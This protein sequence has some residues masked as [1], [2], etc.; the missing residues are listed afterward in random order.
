MKIK[1][2]F[3]F[4]LS[5]LLTLPLGYFL[6]DRIEFVRTAQRINAT[7]EDI[8]ASNDRCGRKRARYACTKYQARLRY[9]VQGGQYRLSVSAGQSRG[10][11]QPISRAEYRIGGTDVVAY[12]PRKPSRGYRDRTWDIWG[13]PVVTFFIQIAAF[14]GS[15]SEQR[16]RY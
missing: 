6:Y 5:L 9:E 3:L 12:D 7:V 11:N 4:G 2:G 14:V 13:A 10:H 15:F 16:K 1:S 8:W